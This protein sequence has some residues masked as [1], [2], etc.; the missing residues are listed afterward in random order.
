M[1]SYLCVTCGTQYP[2]ADNPPSAN[3][4]ADSP[5]ARC[6]I[7]EDERQYV[8]HTGQRW[9]TLEELR[10]DHGNRW[11]E[12]EPGLWS[13]RTEP[14]FGIG[15]RAFLVPCGEAN[16]LWDCIALQ[17]DESV[18]RIQ[19]RG[20]LTAIALSHPHYYSTMVKWSH[21]FGG[22]PVYVHA[23]DREW[24]QQPDPVIRFWEGDEYSLGAGL[25]LIRCGGHFRGGTVLHW[26]AGAEGKGSLLTGDLIQ[27]VMDR[28]WVSF[29]YS[30]PNLIPLPGERVDQIVA[31][32]AAYPFERLYNAF[33]GGNVTEDAHFALKRSANRYQQAL[34]G[35]LPGM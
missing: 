35:E 1:P 15:Q 8:G 11:T 31:S 3:P 2:L 9:T 23:A 27:V 32:V 4:P 30:Y 28:R 21:A 20:G 29:M 24:V 5:P 26:E 25:T 33:Q 7:C 18:A 17:N 14:A 10:Q 19:E 13:L 16:I 6:P 34:R 22:V 12:E